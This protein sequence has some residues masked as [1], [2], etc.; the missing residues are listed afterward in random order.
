MITLSVDHD[1]LY[2]KKTLYRSFYPRSATGNKSID[3]SIII[4]TKIINP[5]EK[6]SSS[7]MKCESSINCLI[8]KFN[9]QITQDYR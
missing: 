3:C 2:N 6:I 8:Y 7:F 9:I 1:V 4:A 5:C